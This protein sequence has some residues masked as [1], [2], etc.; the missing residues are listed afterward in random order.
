MSTIMQEY[1]REFPNLFKTLS[2]R[3]KTIKN[4]TVLAPMVFDLA[5]NENEFLNERGMQLY[6]DIA[7]GGTG[8]IT[9]G[10][11]KIDELNS[12]AH[13]VHFES[14]D[15]KVIMP[16]HYFT[17]YVHSFGALASME[18]N[19]N[20]QF[21]MPQFN[22][23]NLGPMGASELVMPNGLH[24][25]EMDEDDMEQVIESYAQAALIVKRGGFDMILLHMAHGWLMGGF[26]SP[27]VN[28]RKD[29]Y[30]GSHENRMRFPLRVIKRIREVVGEDLIIEARISGD[31]YT[32]GGIRIQDAIEYAKI[33][34]A[35][36]NIDMLHVS[37]GT[38]LNGNTRAVM[39]PSSFIA[40]GHNAKLSEAVKKAGV[41]IPVG[42]VGAIADPYKAEEIIASGQADYVVMGRQFIAD[43]D[44]VNKV[45]HGRIEDIRPCRRCMHCMDTQRVNKGSVVLDDWKATLLMCCDINPTFGHRA[46]IGEIPAPVKKKKVAVIGGGPGGMMAALEASRRGHIV[47]LYE[48]RD[49]LGG[50]ISIFADRVWFK[51]EDRKYREYLIR[52]I[53]KSDVTVHLSTNAT[54]ELIFETHPD[55]VIVAIGG[56]V[57]QPEFEGNKEIRSM[58]VLGVY[59]NEDK[60]GEKIV[61]IGGGLSGC[62]AALHLAEYGKD[63]TLL[64]PEQDLMPT[65]AL[66]LRNHTMQHLDKNEKIHY[67]VNHSIKKLSGQ[68]VIA[69]NQDGTEKLFEADM[70]VYA[71]GMRN[72]EQ[73]AD[74]FIGT[75]VDVIKVGDCKKIGTI[76]TAVHD[77]YD[78]AASLVY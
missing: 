69:F 20:G 27:L 46:L 58:N 55:A 10:E 71:T 11:G 39:I 35:D 8:V 38:R 50:L 48:R 1:Q 31:E 24:V 74:E 62:E 60:L 45:K 67:F 33:L 41:K 57:Y 30:N 32:E 16:Y 36:G 17:E 49:K 6:G 53:E 14:R 56:K 19:H 15:P 64:T 51:Q 28:H 75:A 29:Q 26:L 7:K 22:P 59:N 78:A 23:Q 42:T 54:K 18:F 40:H 37:C 25:K 5:M 73:D 61:I 66:S 43:P 65:V 68:G 77:G 72:R 2:I 4:R 44:W 70:V 52:Q 21:A 63:I 13:R 3:G 47:D 76:G 12:K 9:L 34:E